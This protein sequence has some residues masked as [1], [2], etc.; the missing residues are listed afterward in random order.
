MR[1]NLTATN[2]QKENRIKKKTNEQNTPRWRG[3]S[4]KKQIIRSECILCY[5]KRFQANDS[6]FLIFIFVGRRVMLNLP[7]I[8]LFFLS[9]SF[10]S[11]S[12]IVQESAIHY[13]LN[14]WFCRILW[15]AGEQ[16][17]EHSS[18]R[19]TELKV[20][21]NLYVIL[22]FCIRMFY[23]CRAKKKRGQHSNEVSVIALHVKFSLIR[24][25]NLHWPCWK[26]KLQFTCGIIKSSNKSSIS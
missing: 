13:G 24:S 4:N 18:K 8:S 23:M 25:C 22:L 12:L 16:T 20:C 9:L 1:S 26:S 6:Y 15:L 19:T 3:S 10:H 14:F 7:C 5:M 11:F 17:T 2:V 21:G